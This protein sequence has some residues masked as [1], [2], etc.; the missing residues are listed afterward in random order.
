MLDHAVHFCLYN[1][2]IVAQYYTQH[3]AVLH[4]V[5]LVFS[6][7]LHLQCVCSPCVLMYISGAEAARTVHAFRKESAADLWLFIGRDR[8]RGGQQRAGGEKKK[9][10][11]KRM[12]RE[13]GHRET[14]TERQRETPDTHRE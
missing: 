10:K 13:R 2:A 3:K 8:P 6:H 5:V 1:H 11:E 4:Q 9:K 7:I 14:H 12:R